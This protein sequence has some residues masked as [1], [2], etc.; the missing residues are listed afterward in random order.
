MQLFFFRSCFGS[1]QSICVE[2]SFFSPPQRF[3]LVWGG[4]R[5]KSGKRKNMT[6][7]QMQLCKQLR[8]PYWPKLFWRHK[9]LITCLAL[10]CVSMWMTF[11][12][13]PFSVQLAIREKT[14]IWE[15]FFSFLEWFG[16]YD[17]VVSDV[18]SFSSGTICKFVIYSQTVWLNSLRCYWSYSFKPPS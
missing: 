10:I 6:K 14:F 18:W 9:P 7:M 4:D 16:N 1:V 8:W 15:I 2:N 3:H 13:L 5:N 11:L 17:S 12:F